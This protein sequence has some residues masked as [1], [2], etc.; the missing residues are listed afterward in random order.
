VRRHANNIQDD[1][2]NMLVNFFFSNAF[3]QNLIFG[4]FKL[5]RYFVLLKEY[6]VG[7]KNYCYSIEQKN[8]FS[9]NIVIPNSK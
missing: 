2:A 7:E 5:L 3:I 6:P 9:V 8:N 4:I 1:S